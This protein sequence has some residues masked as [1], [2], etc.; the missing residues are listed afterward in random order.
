MFIE[1]LVAQGRPF[2][3]CDLKP[4]ETL[5]LISDVAG[6][7]RCLENIII[8]EAE[9][10]DDFKAVLLP[11]QTWGDYIEEGDSNKRKKKITFIP[12]IERGLGLPFI[13]PGTGNPTAPQGKYGVPVYL[14][15]PKQ[16]S[17]FITN[18]SKVKAFWRGRLE[19]TLA[20][21]WQ[22]SDTDVFI[23]GNLLKVAAGQ[24]EARIKEKQ[25]QGYGLVSLVFP[26][27][28]GP[29][30][31]SDKRPVKGD[32]DHILVGE[33]VLKPG[34]FIVAHLPT[35]AELFWF[36]KIEEGAEEGK[37]TKCSFCGKNG[38]AVSVYS[39]AWSWLAYT[40]DCPLSEELKTKKREINL[41]QA[42]GALC[43]D[44]YRALIVGAGIF[45]ELAGSLAP[46]LTKEIFLPVASAGGRE[47]KAK[48]KVRL[49]DIRGV[50]LVLP[51]LEEDEEAPEYFTE[52]LT[53]LRQKNVRQG[54]K[55]RFLKA[56]TGF[57]AVLPDEFN[58]DNYRLTLV[59]FTEANA[60]VHLRAV[61]EDVLPSTVSKL[62]DFIPQVIGEAVQ[63]WRYLK[64][65]EIQGPQ[66][67]NYGSL[68]YLL[69]RAYGGCYLWHTLE[70]ILHKKPIAW[71]TFVAGAASRMNGWGR[72]QDENRGDKKN[73]YNLE[74]EVI[75]YWTFRYF[76]SLYNSVLLKGGKVMASWRE[77]IDKIS[78]TKIE[79]LSINDVEELGFA[80]GYLL[81]QFKSWY[82]RATGGQN[83]GKDFI[84]HRIMSFGSTLTPDVIWRRG[85]SRVQEYALK[86]NIPLS[87]DFR[88][89]VGVVES[90]YRRKKEEVNAKKDEFIGAF[91][92][93]YVLANTVKK[94][95]LAPRY[96]VWVKPII[97]KEVN[98]F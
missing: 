27:T 79:E 24:V 60:D 59:Y 31:Y 36:S 64:G 87:D 68:F 49:P 20:L 5:R 37:R 34:K 29:Y 11:L 78:T 65:G 82:W 14:I 52:A 93:G 28:S 55:D 81:G 76:Y 51:L 39:K 97:E 16:V 53:T 10:E 85:L 75:F 30:R 19:R 38:E 72:V 95:K 12:D 91:W 4:S 70:A 66:N 96:F 61:I 6:E 1:R 32:P 45:N 22:L 41:A 9:K 89:R 74:N 84:K 33:S 71:D 23:L 17:E 62:L 21:P 69:N 46:Q 63:I 86:L 67:S 47:E 25:S 50:A 43:P 54:K 57:E 15:F 18:E 88:H 40:W 8:I 98:Y 13:K 77:M 2:L 35:V 7:S 44:C 58:S 42:I 73:Y 80:A 48:S 90:E 56:I 94:N 26:N 3:N 92:S 83:G